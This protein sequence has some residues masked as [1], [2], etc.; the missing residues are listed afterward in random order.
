VKTRLVAVIGVL[1]SASL[2]VWRQERAIGA[3]G[4]F[5]RV[6]AWQVRRRHGSALVFDGRI[7]GGRF[8]VVMCATASAV[9][10][11]RA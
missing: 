11:S 7:D 8:S 1:G 4:P 2:G 6:G 10:D 5:R 9:D 3:C